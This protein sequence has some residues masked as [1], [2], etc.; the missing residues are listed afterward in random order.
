MDSDA[1]S[2]FDWDDGNRIKC[3]KHDL[4]LAEV[5][6]VFSHSHHIAPDAAHSIVETRYLAIGSGGK[7]RPI[8]VSFT[9]RV[10]GNQTL[11]RPISARYMHQEEVEYYAQETAPTDQ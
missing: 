1:V 8:F 7:E 2:G 10:S 11:I 5:E 4:S 3:Q 9:L 6:A